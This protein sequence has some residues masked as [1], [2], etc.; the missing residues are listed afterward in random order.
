MRAF[1]YLFAGAVFGCGLAIAGMTNPAKVLGFLDLTGQWDPSLALVMGGALTT[2]LLGG[3]VVLKREAPVHGGSFPGKPSHEVD[4]RLVGGSALF[5][6]GW[7][8]AGFC[9]GPAVT[10]LAR[11]DPMVFG[12]VGAM[13]A[14]MLL[15]QQLFGSDA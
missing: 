3:R 13:V 11:L 6:I 7:G 14:G 5:G 15:A 2:Y 8:L 9:P 1:A 4:V 12:F 10:N